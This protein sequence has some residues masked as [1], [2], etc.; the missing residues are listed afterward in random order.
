[1]AAITDSS[2]DLSN[3]NDNSN[4]L[5]PSNNSK[6]KQKYFKRSRKSKKKKSYP[7]QNS[8]LQNEK[9]PNTLSHPNVEIEYVAEKL[10]FSNDSS[11]KEFEHI[12][13]SFENKAKGINPSFDEVEEESNENTKSIDVEQDLNSDFNEVEQSKRKNKKAQRIAIADLKQ[14]V[15]NPEVVEWEDVTAQDPLILTTLK[16]Y[17]NTVPIPRHWSQKRKYLQYKRGLEKP[18]FELPDFIKDTGVTAMRESIK[19]KED[20]M[21]AKSKQRER[22][23]PR[24]NKLVID[25]QRLHDAFFRFQKAPANLTGFGEMFYE[26]KELESKKMDFQPGF[27][28]DELKEALGIPPLAPPPWLLNMQRF[29]PPPSYPDMLIPGLSSPI[30]AGAQWGFHPG[31]WGRPPV[32]AFGRPLYGDVFGVDLNTQNNSYNADN[33]YEMDTAPIKLWG[34]YESESEY[35]DDDEDEEEEDDDDEVAESNKPSDVP[36][37]EIENELDDTEKSGTSLDGLVTPSG[38]S[39][40]PSGLE[41][42]EVIQLRKDLVGR[43]QK[44]QLYTIIPEK[45]TTIGSNLVGSQHIYDLSN[46]NISNSILA[47][48]SRKR[49]NNDSSAGGISVALDPQEIE[50][51]DEDTIRAKY[52]SQISARNN[53]LTIGKNGESAEDLSDMVAEHATQQARKRQRQK[54]TEYKF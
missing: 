37:S 44:K 41:T 40:I 54:T 39:S 50:N 14:T 16:S 35:E 2:I 5:D 25:Y 20:E 51:L 34:E 33:D 38:L 22:V 28:S 19:E 21:R 3:K 47:K 52:E 42:P 18:P 43:D 7:I 53:E 24:M 6:T 27:L 29:G 12:F 31:G 10:D 17:R 45:Q 4:T 9:T 46:A 11:F 8:N 48:P 36:A 23:Q 32:D 49:G 26:G 13:K 30:P 15:D 1:M